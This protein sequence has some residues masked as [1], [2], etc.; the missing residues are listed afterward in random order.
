MIRLDS[1]ARV[2]A[3]AS[4]AF[5]ATA[6]RPSAQSSTSCVP[7]ERAELAPVGPTTLDRCGWAVALDGRTLVVGAVDD[8]ELGAGAG[9]AYVFERRGPTH[10][11]WVEVA[12]LTASDAA[13]GDAFG[14][15]VALSGD[16]VAVGAN[17]SGAAGALSGAVYLYERDLGGPDAWGERKRILGS[18]TKAGDQFGW[19]V[20]LSGDVLVVGALMASTNTTGA[21]YV[22]ERDLGGPDNWGQRKKL[23]ASDA[24]QDDRFGRAVSVDGDSVL[25][26]A[27]GN[28]DAG[29]SSGS[30][31]LFARNVGGANNWGQGKKLTAS[32]PFAVDHFG[33]DGALSGDTVVIGAHQ[34]DTGGLESGSAYVFERNLGGTNVWGERKK[35]VASDS[36]PGNRFGRAVAIRGDW[37]AVGAFASAVSGTSSGEAY[38]FERDE[39]GAENWGEVSAMLPSSAAP[40]LTFGWD[41]AVLPRLVAL[42]TPRDGILITVPGSTFL[43]ACDLKT[44]LAPG[45]PRQP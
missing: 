8:A 23:L 39:G 35:L 9:A 5:L 41:V 14:F 4:A 26:T 36:M 1:F 44:A 33:I 38:V 28:D 7:L 34:E 16:V 17:D 6:Q 3:L 22:F 43:F 25:V 18:D 30:A 32:D 31:Y 10:L 19:S 27:D 12:K 42:G 24:A 40:G 37:I 2:V 13:A 21:A 15:S 45:A 29:S 11:A 20:S